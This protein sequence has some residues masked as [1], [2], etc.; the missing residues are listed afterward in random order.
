MTAVTVA[1]RHRLTDR[2][3]DSLTADCSICGPAVAIRRVGKYFQCVTAAREAKAA[4]RKRHPASDKADKMRPPSAHRLMVRDGREDTCKVCGVVT[5]VPHG[6]GWMCPNRAAELGF[7]GKAT[8]V[9]PNQKCKTCA[10]WLCADGHCPR[11]VTELDFSDLDWQYAPNKSR[12]KLR[13]FA[14]LN[15]G[16]LDGFTVQHPEDGPTSLPSSNESVVEGWKTIGSWDF[17]VD[18]NPVD[19]AMWAHMK[20]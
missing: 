19:R 11:C 8:K 2:D 4:W 14:G 6:R 7:T 18:D 5:P 1:E 3:V 17:D 15:Y 13:R 9:P 16:D 10:A 20:V 12:Q